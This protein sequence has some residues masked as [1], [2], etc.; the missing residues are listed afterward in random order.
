[1]SQRALLIIDLQNDYYDGGKWPLHETDKA[2]DNAVKLL[3]YFRDTGETVIHVRH[4]FTGDDAPFFETGSAGA[5]IHPRVAPQANEAVVLKHHVNSFL[6]TNL[7]QLLDDAGVKD[8]IVIGAMSHM[9]IDAG[10]RA[11]SDFGYNCIV[12]Q[13]AC[14]SRD[15]EFDTDI[16]PA[17]HVHKAY[18]SAL[19]FAYARIVNTDEFLAEE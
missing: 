12:A 17:E 8:L 1:M 15:L 3:Q 19:S 13:D 7:K 6:E 11:A 9:C 5:Q 10:V 14:A 4:E 18:M 16:V 2:T